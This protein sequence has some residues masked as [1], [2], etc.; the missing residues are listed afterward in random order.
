MN[1]IF[2]VEFIPVWYIILNI[3]KHIPSHIIKLYFIE[4]NNKICCG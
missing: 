2:F 4:G 3:D 1:N